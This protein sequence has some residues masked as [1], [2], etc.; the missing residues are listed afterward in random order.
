[1]KKNINLDKSHDLKDLAGLN[2][3]H[4]YCYAREVLSGSM[5]YNF[6]KF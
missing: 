5:K 4:G 6:E 1:M 3:L 2:Y